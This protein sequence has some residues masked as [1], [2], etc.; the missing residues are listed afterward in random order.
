MTALFVYGTL[1]TGGDAHQDVLGDVVRLV[2]PASMPGFDLFGEGLPYPYVR[3][4]S[5]T[6]QGELLE[7]GGD[8]GTLAV[9]DRYEGREYVRRRVEV[10][11]SGR[12]RLA[13]AYVARPDVELAE[14]SRIPSGDWLDR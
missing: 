1:R 7:L 13:W 4:G 5:G 3:P 6:V 11:V 14:G 12:P 10:E 9:L 2:H 8:D